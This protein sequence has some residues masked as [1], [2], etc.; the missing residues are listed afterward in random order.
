M[1]I[2]T[3]KD[4]ALKNYLEGR[5]LFERLRYEDAS[6]YFDRALKDDPEFA[7]A[8]LNMAWVQTSSNY[9]YSYYQRA[10]ASMNKVSEGEQL[11]LKAWQA[12]TNGQ[13][14]KNETYLLELAEKFPKDERVLYYTGTFY[15]GQHDFA[16]SII[17]YKRA[18]QINPSFSPA[19]NQIGYAYR[20]LENY[21]AAEES[22][23]KYIKLV[24]DDP[25]PYDSYAE[26][27]LK[28][29]EY[30]VSLETYEKALEAA[31]GF[32]P[33]HY[34]IASNLIYMREYG[35]AREQLKHL[36]KI[37][38][39]DQ[40]KRQAY[41]GC[42]ASYIAENNY[43]NAIEDLGKLLELELNR[44]D[45]SEA[46]SVQY[47]MAVILFEFGEFEQAAQLLDRSKKM[48]DESSL[49]SVR[50]RNLT[51]GY[52]F[53]AARLSIKMGKIDEAKKY[54]NDLFNLIQNSE[55]QRLFTYH[56]SLL[57]LI[58]LKENDYNRAIAEFKQS[59]LEDAFNRYRLGIAYEKSGDKEAAIKELESVITDN[60]L[61]SINYVMIRNRA[62]QK[63]TRLKSD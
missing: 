9:R 30:E 32:A 11:W 63:L 55:N 38:T 52:L 62:E 50:V 13:V 40:Q 37:S 16:K 6:D 2:T 8:A 59:N 45:I 56:H 24:P 27:L 15:F 7:L 29:G 1:S 23:K 34:G 10:F 48:M 3:S 44:S 19:Y 47:Q 51:E 39:N 31:P 41:Y 17:Y 14:K 60:G 46:I 20:Y 49:D 28:M 22:F 12:G 57:G 33:S 4:T 26:L 25:N 53:N 58:A 5:E 54:T 36:Y 42:A 18:I 35:K 61:A 43:K 21:P